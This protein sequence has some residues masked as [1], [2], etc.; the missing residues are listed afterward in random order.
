MVL[1]LFF[2]VDKKRQH[3]IVGR[4]AS[5]AGQRH[6]LRGWPVRSSSRNMGP[7]HSLPGNGTSCE[8]DD[9]ERA[10]EKSRTRI[11]CRATARPART[12]T[13]AGRSASGTSHPLPGNGTPC[14][15]MRGGCGACGAVS[16]ASPAG[17]RH[18]LRDRTPSAALRGLEFS[19]S[20]PGNG[21]SCESPTSKYLLPFR[22]SRRM[23]GVP[24]STA[25]RHALPRHTSH[26]IVR[27]LR[28]AAAPRSAR[29]AS[30]RRRSPRSW[31]AS[32][33]PAAP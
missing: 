28:S 9:V 26:S 24:N 13:S 3:I 31:S 19:H 14:E 6:V 11:P 22:N 17:Q 15:R 21:T 25:A 20:L 7:S 29:P 23:R 32:A 4:L 18:V 16:L 1:L 12:T 5:P 27:P 33:R 10:P 8:A 2:G 30:A